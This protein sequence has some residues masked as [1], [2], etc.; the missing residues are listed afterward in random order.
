[1]LISILILAFVCHAKTNPVGIFIVVTSN[2]Q[3]NLGS[4]LAFKKQPNPNIWQFSFTKYRWYDL[5]LNKNIH[6]SY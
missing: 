4:L 5:W 6:I 2:L 1:M 3:T